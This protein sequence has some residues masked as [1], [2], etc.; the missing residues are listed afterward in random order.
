VQLQY[1]SARPAGL[2]EENDGS[3][4]EHHSDGVIIRVMGATFS[5]PGSSCVWSS[6]DSSQLRPPD[7]K[8]ANRLRVTQDPAA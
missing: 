7:N 3:L 5:D 2:G 1:A 6:L 8:G 4:K